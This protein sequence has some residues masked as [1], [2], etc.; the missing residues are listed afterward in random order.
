M[1]EISKDVNKIL[2][3][4]F[5]I[6]QIP[7]AGTLEVRVNNALVNNYSVMGKVITF[8]EAP[9]DG[10]EITISYRH[11]TTPR[12]KTFALTEDP[13]VSTVK[14]LVNS[15]MVDPKDYVVNK[16]A[17]TITFNA[18]PADNAQISFQYRK[19]VPLLTEFAFNLAA[20]LNTVAV[21]VNGVVTTDYTLDG[22]KVK[23]NNPPVDN[24]KI[25]IDFTKN[26]GP[27]LKY[28]IA[29]KGEN[30]KDIKVYDWNGQEIPVVW[31][32]ESSISLEAANH[33]EGEKLLIKYRNEN[34][35]LLEYTLPE[36]V[37]AT[38]IQVKTSDEVCAYG[39]DIV[40]KENKIIVQCSFEGKLLVDIKYS[41]SIGSGENYTMQEI[42]NPDDGQW[43]VT[44][45]G[46]ETSA[47]V[48]NGND[49]E[50]LEKTENYDIIKITYTTEE[51][52]G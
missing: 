29:F 23:F 17:K 9:V 37:L 49:F 2:K 6:A 22:Y 7:D 45:N 47:F 32:T 30:S 16:A 42:S 26:D 21:K 14:V 50:I 20:V 4:Q 33:K 41:V 25:E 5:S 36:G 52:E 46:K 1:K 40:F 31:E 51:K 19:D 11:G 44:I 10:A 13:A 24:A 18:Q 39:K 38:S 12:Y 15:Q 43:S 28:A 35:G 8:N 27:I 34:S 48:R 3:S